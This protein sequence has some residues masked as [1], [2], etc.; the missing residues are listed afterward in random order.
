MTKSKD[1][2]MV[3]SIESKLDSITDTLNSLS[4]RIV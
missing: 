4:C 3:E 2:S 1:V